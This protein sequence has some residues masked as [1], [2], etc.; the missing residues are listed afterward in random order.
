MLSTVNTL[1][2]P[3]SI[4]PL[5]ALDH[6]KIFVIEKAPALSGKDQQ[7]FSII[8]INLE[9][10]VL[11]QVRAPPFDGILSAYCLPQIWVSWMKAAM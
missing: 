7:R 8:S 2:L 10:H 4:K 11:A 3:A 6:A 9:F 1:T 5:I